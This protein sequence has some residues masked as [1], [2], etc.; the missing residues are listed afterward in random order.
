[1]NE[2][3]RT[4]FIAGWNWVADELAAFAGTDVHLYRYAIDI[5]DAAKVSVDFDGFPEV[6]KPVC[7]GQ[8]A[9]VKAWLKHGVVE[10]K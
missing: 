2:T 4:N 7:Y 6:H 1:M 10:S 9:C 5:L 3:T 8:I